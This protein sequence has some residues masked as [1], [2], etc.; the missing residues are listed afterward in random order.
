MKSSIAVILGVSSIVFFSIYSESADSELESLTPLELY[1]SSELI[2]VGNVISLREDPSKWETEYDVKVEKYLKNPKSFSLITVVGVG[3][4][5]ASAED[6]PLF[7]QGDRVLL[8][9]TTYDGKYRIR[10][11]SFNAPLACDE[12]QLLQLATIPGEPRGISSPA[13]NLIHLTDTFGTERDTFAVIEEINI[14]YDLFNNN[15]RSNTVEV[16]I[17]ITTD[18]TTV[19]HT[20]QII[21]LEPCTNTTISWN[22][23]PTET[24]EYTVNV[25]SEDISD[26]TGFQVRVNRSGGS[27]SPDKTIYPVPWEIRP[28]LKQFKDGITIQEIHCK[29]NLI[30]VIKSSNGYPACVK[31]DSAVKLTGRGW[32]QS[33]WIG[34]SGEEITNYEKVESELIETKTKRLGIDNI[35]EAT[36]SEE[37]SYDEKLEFI[38]YNYEQDGPVTTPSLNLRIKDLPSEFEYGEQPTFTLIETGYAH[39]CTSPKLEVFLAKGDRSLYNISEDIPIYEEQLVYPC[40]WF[41]GYSPIL[42]YRTEKDYPNFPSCMYEGTHIIVGDSGTERHALGEYYCKP[43]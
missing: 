3:T 33:F 10:P 6:D 24:G 38:K 12:H 28:P 11:F 17:A 22:F 16:Q 29:E 4:K 25:T 27:F 40:P 14:D 32:T 5:D 1:K 13:R 35:M 37:L 20:N 39:P 41:E 30:R 36:D 9:L 23:T 31:Y 8:Y 26:S 15:P 7:N 42:S 43:K 21:P 34:A 18:S 19:F 2:L